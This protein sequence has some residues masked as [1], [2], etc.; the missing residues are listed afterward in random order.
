MQP[1]AP[2]MEARCM[3]GRFDLLEAVDSTPDQRNTT[4]ISLASSLRIVFLSSWQIQE[5]E[6]RETRGINTHLLTR[7]RTSRLA[8]QHEVLPGQKL[9][10]KP[11]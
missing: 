8:Y 3:P 2:M 6:Y 9:W 7:M 5:L 1:N 4:R 11:W 10:P